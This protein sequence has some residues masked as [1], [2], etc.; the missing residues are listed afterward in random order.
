MQ[1]L[2]DVSQY[3]IIYF[4]ELMAVP[5]FLMGATAIDFARLKN[6]LGNKLHEVVIPNI[7]VA[8]TEVKAAFNV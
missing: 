6:N 4:Q 3:R 2:S 8:R 7:S 5:V 1:P